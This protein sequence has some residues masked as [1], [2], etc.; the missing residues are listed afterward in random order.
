VCSSR[1]ISKLLFA[2]DWLK[3]IAKA[4]IFPIDIYSLVQQI[5]FLIAEYECAVSY[6]IMGWSASEEPMGVCV[7]WYNIHVSFSRRSCRR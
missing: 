4:T 2:D 7:G 3:S 5:Y 1:K 6:I